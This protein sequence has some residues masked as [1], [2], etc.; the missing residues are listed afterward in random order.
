[1]SAIFRTAFALY[2]TKE[3]TGLPAKDLAERVGESVAESKPE[4]F[5]ADKKNKLKERLTL[6]LELDGS[7]GVTT[8]A[9]DVMME[10]ERTYCKA[11]IL[12]DIRPVFVGDTASSAVIIHNLQLGF[13][14]GGKHQEI[15]I[16]LDTDDL[17]QLK[18]VIVRAEKKTSVLQQMLE[19]SGTEYLPV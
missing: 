1:V 16:A 19:K 4:I 6:L 17:Q 7:L 5:P 8:K 3:Q 12:S 10:H 2:P 15:Y 14:Y 11:R 9:L 18:S 13:H